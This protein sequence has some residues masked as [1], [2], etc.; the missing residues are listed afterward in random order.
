M[1]K[2]LRLRDCVSEPVGE[3]GRSASDRERPRERECVCVF[4]SDR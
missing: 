2:T 3:W 4:D 1:R